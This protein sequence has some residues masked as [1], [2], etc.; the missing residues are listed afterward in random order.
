MHD[1]SYH[2]LK[3][4][5]VGAQSFKI[6]TLYTNFL[7]IYTLYFAE[8]GGSASTEKENKK[9]NDVEAENGKQHS[10]YE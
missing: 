8:E 6:Y 4:K 3:C 2:S 9:K 5:T 10:E 7:Q 1:A